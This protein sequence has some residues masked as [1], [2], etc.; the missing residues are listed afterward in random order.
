VTPPA[1]KLNLELLRQRDAGEFTR[2]VRQHE[3]LVMG[4]CQSLRLNLQDRE[5]AAAETFASAYRALGNFRGEAEL[6]TWLYRIAY[7]TALKVRRRYPA[8]TPMPEGEREDLSHP[9][10]DQQAQSREEFAVV[11]KAVAT[12]E[13]EPAAV[14]EM[15][16]R[17]G[18]SVKEIAEVMERPEAT[19]KTLLFRARERLR[20]L[21]MVRENQT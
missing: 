14:M 4:L 2:F 1:D 12:L 7:R 8:G 5:D 18:L 9:R 10:P 15:Y 11:W 20:C 13:P 21:L 19:V 6:S 3:G 17:R 16:Y